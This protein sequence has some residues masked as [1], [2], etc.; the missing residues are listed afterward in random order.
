MTLVKT[1]SGVPFGVLKIEIV[2][3]IFVDPVRL[4]AALP[5]LK[6]KFDIA[7]PLTDNPEQYVVYC[8]VSIINVSV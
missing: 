3:M 1:K 5:P 6:K 4:I 2:C 8:D 7:E